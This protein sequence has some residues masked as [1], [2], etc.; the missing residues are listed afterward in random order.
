MMQTQPNY[1]L[2]F[3]LSSELCLNPSFCY[4]KYHW[5]FFRRIYFFIVKENNRCYENSEREKET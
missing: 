1:H 2:E 5:W 4:T 3:G